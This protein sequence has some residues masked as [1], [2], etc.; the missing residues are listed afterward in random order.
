MLQ[1]GT[2]C[3][4][5]FHSRLARKPAPSRGSRG[6]VF[7]FRVVVKAVNRKTTHPQEKPLECIHL[8]CTQDLSLSKMIWIPWLTR[9][10]SVICRRDLG[11]LAC[12]S[13]GRIA[14]QVIASTPHCSSVALTRRWDAERA[15]TG[16]PRSGHL[17]HRTQSRA[18]VMIS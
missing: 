17:F 6:S 10:C 3:A 15:A 8:P 13:P 11:A 1:S 16:Q 18:G 4:V 2:Q 5:L 7:T 14:A 12:A 9:V